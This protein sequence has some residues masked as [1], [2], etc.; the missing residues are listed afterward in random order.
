MG[1]PNATP[2]KAV[3]ETKAVEP[4]TADA[5]KAAKSTKESKAVELT[6]AE[7]AKAVKRQVPEIG[8][9]GKPTGEVKAVPVKA[10]EIFA[11]AVRGDRVTVVTNDGQKLEGKL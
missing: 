5:A 3:K 4:T 6:A 10:D 7:A 8:K 2:D 9:D 11:W 1:D